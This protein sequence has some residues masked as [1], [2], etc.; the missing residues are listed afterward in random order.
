MTKKIVIIAIGLV[1]VLLNIFIIQ[2]K[3]I[4]VNDDFNLSMSVIAEQPQNYQI[5]YSTNGIFS[6]EQSKAVDYYDINTSKDYVFSIPSNTNYIRIDL[7]DRPSKSTINNLCF[8]YKNS[9]YFIKADIIRD[10]E[11]NMVV[12]IDNVTEKSFVITTNGEDPYF[13]IDVNKLDLKVFI[14]NIKDNIIIIKNIVLCFLID[15]LLLL[16]IILSN[17]LV[18]LPVEL[19]R[20]RK[21]IL[22][23]AV[24]DFKTKYAGSYLGIIWAFIQPI[25]TILVYWFVFQVGFRSGSVGTYPFVLWFI[26]GIIPWFFF[27]DALTGGSNSFIEYSYLVKKVVFRISVLPLVKI[28]S[29]LIVHIFFVSF[30]VLLFTLNKYTPDLYALQIVYYTL[31]MFVLVLGISYA[32]S[33]ILVFFK[34]LGQIINIFL[35]VGMWMT[36]IMWNYTMVPEKYRFILKINPMYYIVEGYR[37]S[38]IYKVWF[39]E[40]TNLLLYFWLITIGLFTIGALIFKRLKIHFADVL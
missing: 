35:Q 13:I 12:K 17:K 32:T 38:L 24:N 7:G 26:S 16:L 5:F 25:I 18:V 28:I 21:L 8:E 15:V 27:A 20:N 40:N 31:C 6:E 29:A 33:S 9:R 30:L 3:N 39:W 11:S 1:G 22:K 23:L 19:Y 2:N 36:P 34:D 37:N 14:S 4:Y 10:S